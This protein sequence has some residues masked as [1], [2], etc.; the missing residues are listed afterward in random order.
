MITL[1]IIAYVLVVLMGGLIGIAI[2]DTRS[3]KKYI[4]ELDEYI[5]ELD[6]RK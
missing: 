5:K 2:N 6:E 3:K 1:I 4:K